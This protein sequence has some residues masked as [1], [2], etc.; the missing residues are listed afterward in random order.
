MRSR[1]DDPA[2]WI[3]KFLRTVRESLDPPAWP[4]ADT[5]SYS[6]FA[7]SWVEA[8]RVAK[9]REPDALAAAR[10]L[11]AHPP[12]R[13]R[14][15]LPRI[16][17]AAEKARPSG[18]G[19]SQDAARLASKGC[20]RCSGNGLAVV[21]HPTPGPEQRIPPTVGAYCVCSLGR[22]IKHA[23]STRK[24]SRDVFQRTPDLADILAGRSVWTAEPAQ[25]VGGR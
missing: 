2:E 6:Q 10:K 9:V 14:D 25:H 5:E 4:E 24:D 13:R 15:Y 18:E 23:H 20:E 16:L 11:A 12:A 8:F 3:D 1:E 22:W 17:E 21:Y 19:A 7:M